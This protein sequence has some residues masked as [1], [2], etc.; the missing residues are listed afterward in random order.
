MRTNKK[1]K[2]FSDIETL[3]LKLTEKKPSVLRKLWNKCKPYFLPFLFGMML[4][5]FIQPLLWID[6]APAT[7]ERQAAMGG[8]AIPFPNETTLPSPSA[9]PPSD[10]NKGASGLLWKNISALPLPNNRQADAG[11]TKSTRLFRRLVH[12]TR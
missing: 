8:A 11:Q 7:L 9:L 5:N 1:K 3:L 4:G 10:S 2:R 12:L 6:I